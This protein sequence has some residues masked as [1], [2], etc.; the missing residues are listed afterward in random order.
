[1]KP[2]LSTKRNAAMTL[3][4]VGVIVAVVM[5]LIVIFLPFSRD[6]RS[7]IAKI[8]CVNNLKQLGLAYKIWEGDN[9][10]I[11]PM[12]FPS[13]TVARWKWFKLETLFKLFWSCRMS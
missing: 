2:R 10:D 9:G 6:S 11:L 5:I 3:F 4:E 8:N 1:M 12:G 7:R 13:P